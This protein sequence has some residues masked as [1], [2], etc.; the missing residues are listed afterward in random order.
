MANIYW[1][2]W[3]HHLVTH[4]IALKLTLLL[5]SFFCWFISKY[6]EFS[7]DCAF[8]D[9]VT[10]VLLVLATLALF[11]NSS[12]DLQYKSIFHNQHV[13]LTINPCKSKEQKNKNCCQLCLLIQR[14]FQSVQW[15]KTTH[16]FRL[17]MMKN[18]INMTRATMART[19]SRTTNQYWWIQPSCCN[20]T[21]HSHINQTKHSHIKN[22]QTKHSHI[23]IN[24]TK[25]SFQ[26]EPNKTQSKQQ[27]NRTCTLSLNHLTQKNLCYRY[28]YLNSLCLNHVTTQ[29]S[30][31]LS[32]YLNFPCL[33][34]VTPRSL[35]VSRKHIYFAHIGLMFASKD[36]I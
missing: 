30:R 24:Q 13:S 33:T 9:S 16:F 29:G 20:Q 17:M 21:K 7:K 5:L 3:C 31:Y 15:K 27:A 22:N 36:T 34:N 25:Q 10:P 1:D 23:N 28:T 18:V 19:I 14:T 26:Q 6:R 35:Y 4:G 12:K 2:I 8:W 11:S 32:T